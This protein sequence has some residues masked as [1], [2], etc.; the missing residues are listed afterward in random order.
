MLSNA[1]GFGQGFDA[2]YALRM[3]RAHRTG[4]TVD[5]AKLAL[6]ANKKRQ[7]ALTSRVLCA[8]PYLLLSPTPTSVSMPGWTDLTTLGALS[9]NPACS[10]EAVRLAPRPPPPS[11]SPPP[12]TTTAMSKTIPT[13][14]VAASATAMKRCDP[15]VYVS[16]ASRAVARTRHVL[17]KP[18]RS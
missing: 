10:R 4:V 3:E 11:P 8:H 15:F 13:P 9:A 17:N 2:G 5:D 14:V 18:G 1:T 6:K 16:N 12:Q 7:G